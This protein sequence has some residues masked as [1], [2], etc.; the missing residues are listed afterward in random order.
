MIKERLWTKEFGSSERRNKERL[1]GSRDALKDQ[2]AL[3]ASWIIEGH[4]T[5]HD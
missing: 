4:G 1:E 2:G 5:A 3:D